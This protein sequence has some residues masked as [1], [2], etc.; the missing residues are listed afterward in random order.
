[1]SPG[2]NAGHVY[3]N[4]LYRLNDQTAE[5]A[6]EESSYFRFRQVQFSVPN[7]NPNSVAISAS[8]LYVA[9]NNSSVVFNNGNQDQ[10]LVVDR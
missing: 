10:I 6:A 2:A 5:N 3:L 4:Q 1:M 9:C 8:R 7:C